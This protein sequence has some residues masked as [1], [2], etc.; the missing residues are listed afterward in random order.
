MLLLL[1][2]NNKKRYLGLSYKFIEAHTHLNSLFL[3]SLMTKQKERE[4]KINE[5]FRTLIQ[6]QD[7]GMEFD[8]KSFLIEI[9]K[10]YKVARRTAR[11]YLQV[12]QSQLG[13]G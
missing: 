10:T 11:E 2:N 8:E 12:A 3:Y 6:M 9:Q 13:V 7:E 4:H 5:I 1:T